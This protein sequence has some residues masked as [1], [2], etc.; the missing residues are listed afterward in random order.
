M[1]SIRMSRC[2][3]CKQLVDKYLEFDS[4]LLWTDISLMKVQ[5]WRHALLNAL[6]TKYVV[7]FCLQILVPSLLLEAYISAPGGSSQF[8]L[9]AIEVVSE[10]CIFI[11]AVVLLT[12]IFLCDLERLPRVIGACVMTSFPKL[13]LFLTIVWNSAS[14]LLWFV[15]VHSLISM[16]IALYVISTYGKKPGTLALKAISVAFVSTTLATAFKMW[17]TSKLNTFV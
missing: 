10:F 15:R 12:A 5:A 7:A 6:T 4:V 1:G 9:R 13:L 3:E 17:L 14:S 16:A 11:L 2:C 8:S